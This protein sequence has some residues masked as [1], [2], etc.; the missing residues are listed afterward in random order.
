[1]DLKER[2][3]SIDI[4][5]L[6]DEQVKTLYIQIGEKVKDIC[7]KAV[8][9]ANRILNLYGMECKMAFQIR[10]IGTFPEKSN[11]INKESD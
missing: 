4:E 11:L 8:W 7:D 1:M 3:R 10:K 2:K 6:S 5:K 9:S